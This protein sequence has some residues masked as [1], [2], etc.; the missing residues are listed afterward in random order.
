MSN[1]LKSGFY[2]LI[3]VFLCIMCNFTNI[4]K[5]IFADTNIAL[6]NS[7]VVSNINVGLVGES[8]IVS[9]S[10]E[11]STI[12]YNVTPNEFKT[13]VE[14]AVFL[15]D[16]S[17][18]MNNPDNGGTRDRI[19]FAEDII[20]NTKTLVNNSNNTIKLKAGVM[21]YSDNIYTF[22]G[23]NTDLSKI[24]LYNM[25]TDEGYG[26]NDR[27]S[28]IA[29]TI[30]GLNSSSRNIAP[31]L[32]KAD[33]LLQGDEN[34][35][36]ANRNKAII[37]IT[38]GTN[39]I[40]WADAQIINIIN[41]G[42]K[43]ITIDISN[44]TTTDQNTID[45]NNL[46]DMTKKLTKDGTYTSLKLQGDGNSTLSDEQKKQLAISNSIYLKV[47][48]VNMNN[49]NE[50]NYSQ[51]KIYIP[52][53]TAA[54][55]GTV[56]ASNGEYEVG[57][58]K[59]TFD[60]GGNFSIGNKAIVEYNGVQ[61]YIDIN[62]IGGNKV[63]IDI[64]K[65]INYEKNVDGFIPTIK[66]FNVSFDVIPIGTGGTFGKDGN[67]NDI[68]NL[69]YT[70]QIAG[71]QLPSKVILISTP[72][73]KVNCNVPDINANLISVN[74]TPLASPFEY[75]VKPEGTATI[76]YHITPTDFDKNWFDNTTI[77]NDVV[78]LLD[79]SKGI[80]NSYYNGYIANGIFN[81]VFSVINNTNKNMKY[82]L[83]TYNNS[84]VYMYDKNLK[85][86]SDNKSAFV[87]INW[88]DINTFGNTMQNSLSTLSTTNEYGNT[89][90]ALEK[91]HSILND[92]ERGAV[93]NIVIITSGIENNYDY[94]NNILND[95]KNDG[96]NIVTLK[97]I[98]NDK[99]DAV[100]EL[101]EKLGGTQEHY[102]DG[103]TG[104]INNNIQNYWMPSVEKSIN[105]NKSLNLVYNSIKF[106][107]DLNNNFDILSSQAIVNGNTKNIDLNNN[108][109]TISLTN[110]FDYTVNGNK[111]TANSFDV[112]FSVK[113]KAGKSGELYF[114][115]GNNQLLYD[116]IMGN[117]ITKDVDTPIII[118]QN[119]TVNHGV[120]KDISADGK[121]EYYIPK[122][123]DL[124]SINSIVP[125]ACNINNLSQSNSTMVLSIDKNCE[126]KSEPKIY[127]FN[128]LTKK[129]EELT[130]YDINKS[131]DEKT[132][133]IT[134]FD[135]SSNNNIIVMYSVKLNGGIT[136]NISVNS[137]TNIPASV[138]ANGD[139][140]DLF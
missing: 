119:E 130:S 69:T 64:S 35:I 106:K 120:Y 25:N 60:L 76:K 26:L 38:S 45:E 115:N 3:A 72:V 71:Q 27:G 95:I 131:Q 62:S 61:E 41:K 16:V 7:A 137:G 129:L 48:P 112:E 77:P 92:N 21:G 83:V 2:I 18:K 59:F 116:T 43:I 127:K 126:I 138:N 44:Q 58:A 84:G 128:S 90:T 103:T 56:N 133:T 85:V 54:I 30:M 28:T 49:N 32:K 78:I 102:I 122:S 124:F 91:A 88:N 66:N 70:E 15:V 29:N 5:N 98:N 99:N 14:S 13:S 11:T 123:D 53:M 51:N 139:L 100:K 94:N 20:R 82:S 125:F 17:S 80:P 47:L 113:P 79:T 96:C 81:K 117:L 73:I 114:G 6:A 24:C 89:N 34:N 75:T 118:V 63:E 1:K 74:N 31:A 65:F 22:W 40:D 12:T 39:S 8:N 36:I 68:S 104:D 46:K 101:H 55:Y 108:I 140:P 110:A 67:G 33:E 57:N 111:Y 121:A 136:N 132:F 105:L 87:G 93:K 23:E 134:N 97:I 135:S 50:Y 107:F 19:K 109:A 37:I 4:T 42:Y 9:Q 86:T 10:G 52:A